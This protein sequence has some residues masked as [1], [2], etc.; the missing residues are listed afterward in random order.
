MKTKIKVFLI[1]FISIFLLSM[2]YSILFNKVEAMN[3][4]GD[5][6]STL[7]EW[8]AAGDEK[9]FNF[10]ALDFIESASKKGL[11]SV[12]Y[13]HEKVA[14]LCYAVQV[15]DNCLLQHTVA[16]MDILGDPDGTVVVYRMVGGKAEAKTTKYKGGSKTDKQ[17]VL[18]AY[19]VA[20]YAQLAIQLQQAGG[21]NGQSYKAMM[22]HW[23]IVRYVKLFERL[24]IPTSILGNVG[25]ICDT[26]CGY[27]SN[28]DP[29]YKEDTIKWRTEAE[30]KW[31]KDCKAILN[32]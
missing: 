7:Q 1:S 2:F 24:G 9:F 32:R 8:A 27:F 15:H 4:T 31:E 16:I 20:R 26:N 19:K 3:I 25:H 23:G 14:G 28:G 10:D 13:S 12:S 18:E 30:A 21:G 22:R 6:Y 17:A 29:Q 11:V 5:T